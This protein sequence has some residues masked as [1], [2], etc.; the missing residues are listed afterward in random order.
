MTSNKKL[1]ARLKKSHVDFVAR[2]DK[3]VGGRVAEKRAMAGLT[4]ADLAAPIGVTTQQ[5]HRYETGENSMDVAT[6]ISV[7]RTM[8]CRPSELLADFDG[9]NVVPALSAEAVAIAKGV[10]GIKNGGLRGIVRVLVDKLRAHER[11]VGK[12]GAE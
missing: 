1:T 12:D 10:D 2:V 8:G 5:A 7:S 11:A 4:Q 3:T 9:D 6:L